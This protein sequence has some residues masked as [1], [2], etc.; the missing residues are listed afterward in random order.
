MITAVSTSLLLQGLFLCSL[1][2]FSL[3]APAVVTITIVDFTSWPFRGEIAGFANPV[4]E[5]YAYASN[6]MTPP[7]DAR[8]CEFP[9][10]LLDKDN[11]TISV[12]LRTPVAMLISL[13]GCNPVTLFAYSECVVIDRATGATTRRR[14]GS[15]RRCAR[16]PAG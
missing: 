13:G 15:A 11:N 2:N 12:E 5:D 14:L 8:L 4:D 10:S 9:P 1:L 6:L 7:D 3:S 16:D